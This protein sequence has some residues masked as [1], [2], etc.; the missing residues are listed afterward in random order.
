MP[1]SWAMHQVLLKTVKL[2][3]QSESGQEAGK[4]KPIIFTG[5][6]YVNNY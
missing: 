1:C 5:E 2:M 3:N 6:F 4:M